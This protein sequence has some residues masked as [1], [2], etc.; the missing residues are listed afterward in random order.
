MVNPLPPYGWKLRVRPER[1]TISGWDW[2][3]GAATLL[4]GIVTFGMFL[5]LFRS[6][7]VG[8]AVW[9]LF[10]MIIAVGVGWRVTIGS[11]GFAYYRTWF[12]IPL[13]SRSFPTG[14]PVGIADDAY[15]PAG[16]DDGKWV[17][18]GSEEA[19]R[20]GSRKNSGSVLTA[21]QEAIARHHRLK[22]T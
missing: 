19:C 16:S 7:A 18:L 2:T 6:T 15:A 11:E 14:T 13:R 5:W 22:A 4:H 21:L 12:G 20:F 3:T 10:S 9:V 17:W 1:T 8:A